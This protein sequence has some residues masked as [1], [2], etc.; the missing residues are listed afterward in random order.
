M[1]KQILFEFIMGMICACILTVGVYA[2]DVVASGTCGDD[3][4]WSIDYDAKLIISG[5]GEM[6]DYRYSSV[7]WERYTAIIKS[8]IIEE[9][10]TT[11]GDCA[12]NGGFEIA[13]VDIQGNITKIGDL[14]FSGCELLSSII[15]PESLLSIGESAFYDCNSL[16]NI[17]IPENV[18]SIGDSAFY[19]C[20]GLTDII[21]GK[22]VT[23]IGEKAFV[24]CQKLTSITLPSG[25]TSIEDN[26]FSGCR[27]LSNI[28]LPIE[29][30]NVGENAFRSCAIKTLT[31]PDSVTTIGEGAF[32]DCGFLTQINIPN[33]VTIIEESTFGFCLSLT[34]ILYNGTISQ[35][36]SIQ[37]KNYWDNNTGEYTI[38]CKDGSI[39]KNDTF[40]EIARGTCGDNLTWV[41]NSNGVLLINGFGDM[42]EYSYADYSFAS[43]KMSPWY[44]YASSIVTV[45]IQ[46]GVTSIGKCAFYSNVSNN[47][48]SSLTDI[49]LPKTLTSI[50][51]DAFSGCSA[52]K[53][54][55]FYGDAPEVVSNIFVTVHEDFTIYYLHTAFGWSTPKWNGYTAYPFYSE[56]EDIVLGDI[57][58]D[59]RLT[60]SDLLYLTKYWAGYS[61][62]SIENI[63]LDVLDMD[64]DGTVTRRD[65]MILERH[66]AGW[67]GYETLPLVKS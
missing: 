42:W 38:Y 60:H 67:K 57:D 49:N 46:E 4:V 20:Y 6:R 32:F 19:M 2:A 58:K 30:Q 43:E 29:I 10:V 24:A 15:L 21:I 34:D 62:Y 39:G 65:T 66:L 55:T 41:L 8:V 13:N 1:R 28:I 12:F 64:S 45:S 7:P 53:T 5:T 16:E 37:R 11:I 35:W 17:I 26:T 56:P 3:L 14:A 22:S 31:L 61:G 27:N 63:P 9:G 52:L 44:K 18:T 36:E 33:N 51:I 40:Y 47:L 59:N 54:A 23:T 25:M 50:G 48:Y